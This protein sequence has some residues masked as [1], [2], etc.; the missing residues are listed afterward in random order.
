MNGCVVAILE[1][2]CHSDVTSSSLE[3]SQL[4]GGYRLGISV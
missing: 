2:K 4:S 1:E 3:T